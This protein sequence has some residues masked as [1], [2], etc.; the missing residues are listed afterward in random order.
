MCLIAFAIGASDHWPLVVAANRDEFRD[1]PTAPL[2]RWTPPSGQTVIGGRDLRAGGAWFSITPAGRV[3]FLTN[4]REPGVPPGR[5][6]RGELVL[7]WL[8]SSA[9]L[10]EFATRLA[11][12]SAQFSGFNLVVGDIGSGWRW[13]SNRDQDRRPGWQDQQLGP[14]VYGLSNAA[15]DTPW[16]K[17]VQLRSVLESAL[18]SSADTNALE[19]TLWTALESSKRFEVQLLP[20]TGVP[21]AMEAALS[22][23]F[24]DIEDMAYGTRSSTLLTAAQPADD[25]GLHG[26]QVR[27]QEREPLR[28]AIGSEGPSLERSRL[29]TLRWPAPAPLATRSVP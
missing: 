21:A 18:Q 23:A 29:E 25:A 8:E 3:A 16:P 14:G 17:T 6:S 10:D 1:R 7:R 11:P 22:S 20:S 2:A 9:G 12:D 5:R 4:V 28:V 13:L 19:G 24:V 15:L 26:L 27:M